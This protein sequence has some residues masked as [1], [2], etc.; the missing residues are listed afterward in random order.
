MARTQTMVQLTQELVA[1]L[2]ALAARRSL[3]RSALIREFVI[4]GLRQST[5]AAMGER[6]ADGYRR[7]PPA[8]PDEWGDPA[9]ASDV[10]TGELLARL[11]A[12]DRAA[13]HDSW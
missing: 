6:I 5:A 9:G 7:V 8:Q 2:D 4:D 13:G 12:E 11:D 10:A 1:S 3:S